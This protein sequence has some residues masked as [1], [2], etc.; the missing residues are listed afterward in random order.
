M[1]KWELSYR[2]VYTHH[3]EGIADTDWHDISKLAAAGWDL[4][5]V[6]PLIEE[7]NTT[8]LLYTFKRQIE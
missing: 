5:S 4:V 3:I 8:G 1:V 6:T 2:T 7:G